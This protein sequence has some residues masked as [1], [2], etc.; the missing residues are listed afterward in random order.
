MTSLDGS[1]IFRNIGEKLFQRGWP[2]M[3]VERLVNFSDEVKERR[4]GVRDC[5]QSTVLKS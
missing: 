3:A 2:A 5:R 1:N 4:S